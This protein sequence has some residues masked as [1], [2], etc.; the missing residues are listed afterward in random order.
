[1]TID[2]E[3]GNAGWPPDMD[4]DALARITRRAERLAAKLSEILEEVVAEVARRSGKRR[5]KRTRLEQTARAT[6]VSIRVNSDNK[7][8]VEIDGQV[9]PLSR[10]LAI[11]LSVISHDGGEVLSGDDLVGWKSL[12]EVRRLIKK[13]TGRPI[14]R[15]ALNERIYILRRY[16]HSLGLSSGL[17]QTSRASGV[18]FAVKR[19]P[20][21]AIESS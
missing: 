15:G 10:S 3:N 4:Q 13:N 21:T 19:N 8:E 1:M 16:L 11:L 20:L 17:V 9:F 5:C 6:Q 2:G 12:D 14:S 18:R 7:Y